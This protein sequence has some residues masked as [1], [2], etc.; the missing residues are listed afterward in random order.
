MQRAKNTSNKG[1]TQ[2]ITFEMFAGKDC[3]TVKTVLDNKFRVK[4]KVK[5][6]NKLKQNTVLTILTTLK[7]INLNLK[8]GC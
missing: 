3:E 8:I 6:L 5:S 7:L 1:W 4:P 2:W